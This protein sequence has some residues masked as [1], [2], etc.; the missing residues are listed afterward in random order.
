MVRFLAASSRKPSRVGF[1]ATF[2]S[3]ASG[4]L[5]GMHRQDVMANNL[6]NINTVGFKPLDVTLAERLP[7]RLSPGPL[8]MFADTAGIPTDSQLLLER[9]LNAP[10]VALGILHRV[11]Q[12]LGLLLRL[13]LPADRG[14]FG[15]DALALF[16]FV[17]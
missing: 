11:R 15:L 8:S 14:Q 1:F 5:A 3:P 6:A 12:R 4:A 9:L 17:Q 7:E 2:L 13:N 16:P 10:G